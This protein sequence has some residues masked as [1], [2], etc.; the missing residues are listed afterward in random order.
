MIRVRSG[1]VFCVLCVVFAIVLC[2]CME[3]QKRADSCEWIDLF[4]GKDL[5]DWDIKVTGYEL[6]ENPGNVFRV[7]GGVLKISYDQFKKFDGEFGHIF[8]KDKFSYYKLRLEYRM[9]G[10]QVP[11]GPGWG[12]RN[13]GIMIHSQSPETMR[14]DQ[15]FPVS[16]EVQLLGGDGSNERSTGNLCTPGTNFVMDGKLVTDH[17]NS[18]SSKTYHGDQWVKAEVHVHGNDVIRHYINGNLV[19]EY[20]QPQL[21]ETDADARK[22]LK[23]MDK[24]LSEGYI[25]LQ[26]ESHPLEFRNIQLMP[27]EN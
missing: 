10:Q 17:C 11:G 15:E 12:F 20:N 7:E 8:Y 21:D 16:I 14:K 1:G 23:T 5:N 27:L 25:A 13:S 9:V 3:G 26:A 2:G 4:N 22:L 6:N 19:M 24:M 18:S